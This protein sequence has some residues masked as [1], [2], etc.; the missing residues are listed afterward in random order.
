LHPELPL[1]KNRSKN[2]ENIVLYISLNAWKKTT[3]FD[4][5]ARSF[6]ELG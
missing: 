5:F 3:K 6:E 4:L 2:I 1:Q